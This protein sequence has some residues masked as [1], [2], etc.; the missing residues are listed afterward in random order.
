[1]TDHDLRM[2]RT[3]YWTW[4]ALSL[5]MTLFTGAVTYWILR[6]LDG[7]L[8]GGDTGSYLVIGIIVGV[9]MT[10]VWKR[11]KYDVRDRPD[12]WHPDRREGSKTCWKATQRRRLVDLRSL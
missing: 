2:T 10:N 8:A 5:A 6:P 7:S 12:K 11:T 4:Q 9:V 1:M 3:Y